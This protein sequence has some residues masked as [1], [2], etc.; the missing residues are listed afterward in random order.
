[1]IRDTPEF[2]EVIHMTV[3][4]GESNA[5]GCAGLPVRR[6]EDIITDNKTGDTR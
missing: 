1:M 6:I 3:S 4:V 2:Y 5:S